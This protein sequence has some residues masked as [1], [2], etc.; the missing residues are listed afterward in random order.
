[1]DMEKVIKV[2]DDAYDFADWL[3]KIQ[4][5]RRIS[6]L[7]LSRLTGISPQAICNYRTR[8]RIPG[9]DTVIIICGALGKKLCIVDENTQDDHF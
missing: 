3:V 1:M 8:Y 7:K 4:K 5:D 9:L 2:L 6:N